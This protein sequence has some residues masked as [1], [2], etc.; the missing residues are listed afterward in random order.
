MCVHSYKLR[1]HEG[2]WL[3]WCDVRQANLRGAAS[4]SVQL[5]MEACGGHTC[6]GS[7]ALSNPTLLT[8]LPQDEMVRFNFHRYDDHGMCHE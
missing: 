3:V 4:S 6:I 8:T 7:H 5:C 1:Y 2:R